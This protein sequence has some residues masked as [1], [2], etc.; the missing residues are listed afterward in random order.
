MNI[1][2]ANKIEILKNGKT[3]AQFFPSFNS[4]KNIKEIKD[5][6][7]MRSRANEETL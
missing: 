1:V 4:M 3:I 6:A 7:P 2:N 5:C